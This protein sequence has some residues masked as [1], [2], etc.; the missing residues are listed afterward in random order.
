VA[1]QPNGLRLESGDAVALDG[2]AERIERERLAG[3]PR[4]ASTPHEA[5][6]PRGHV[7]ATEDQP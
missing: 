7:A 5:G 1:V 3:K 2:D 6:A 4:S